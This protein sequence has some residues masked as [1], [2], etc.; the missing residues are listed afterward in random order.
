MKFFTKLSA[1]TLMVFLFVIAPMLAF[2]QPVND[3]CADAT[4]VTCGTTLSGTNVAATGTGQ[5]TTSCTTTPGNFGV[6]YKYVGTGD[7]VTAATCLTAS[8]DSKINVYSGSCGALV[9]IGGNDDGCGARSTVTFTTLVGTDYYI[10]VTGFGSATS[11]FT[12]NIT[13]TAPLANDLCSTATVVSCGDSLAASN[14]SAT[15]TDQ[16]TA[17]CGTAPGGPGV[18]FHFVGNGDVVTAATCA[19]ASY[20]SKLN[21]YSG[22]CGAATLVCVGGN[23]D[24]CGTRS[25]FTFPSTVGVDYYILVTGFSGATSNFILTINCVTPPPND[26]CATAIPITCASG[27]VYGTNSG[28]TNTGNPTTCGTAPGSA[29]V[30]YTFAGTGEFVTLSTCDSSDYNTKLN[31]YSGSCGTFA[32]VTGNDNNAACTGATTSSEVKFQSVAGVNYYVLV[33]GLG[34]ATGNFGLAISCAPS[35]ATNDSCINALAITCA[36][37]TV[38]GSNVV[39]TGN[40]DPTASCGSV[41]PGAYGVWYSFVGTGDGITLSTCAAGTN[42]DTKLNVYSGTC[43]S[44]VCVTGNDNNATCSTNANSSALSFNSTLGTQYYVLV[45]GN[46]A[47]NGNFDL[48]I[49]CTPPPANDSCVNAIALTCG[50]TVM[51]SNIGATNA[52]QPT[53]SCTT[54]P[55]SYG[56]WYTYTGTGEYVVLSTC[57]A[58][59]FDTKLNVYTGT[60]GAANLVCV[61]GNDNYTSAC[62]ANSSRL[63]FQSTLGTTYYVLVSGL[64]TATG[65]FSLTTTCFGAT[66]L[67]IDSCSGTYTSIANDTI[68]S[69]LAITRDTLNITTNPYDTISDLNVIVEATHS[70][71]GDLYVIL[72]HIP[73]GAVDTIVSRPGSLLSTTCSQNNINAKFDDLAL[74]PIICGPTT[75]TDS[76]ALARGPYQPFRPLSVFNGDKIGGLWEMKIVDASGGD[77]GKLISWCLD[78]TLRPY[79]CTNPVATFSDSCNPANSAFYVLVDVTDLGNAPSLDIT[80]SINGAVV[81]ASTAGHYVVGPFTPGASVDVTLTNSASGNCF[82]TEVGRSSSCVTQNPCV[83]PVATINAYC[84]PTDG[85]NFYVDVVV[86]DIGS[87]PALTISNTANGTTLAVT[88]AGTYTAGPF[89]NN[90][91][92]DVVLSNDTAAGC[93]VTALSLS[94]D[95]TP[96]CTTGVVAGNDTTICA[97]Q[98]VRLGAPAIS[99]TGT[100]QFEDFDACTLPLGWTISRTQ[101]TIDWSIG[102]PPSGN[103]SSFDGIN[104]TCLAYYDDDAAGNNNWNI[105]TLKSPPIDATTFITA[106]LNLDLFYNADE[107]SNVYPSNF[108]I[109]VWD[110]T[111]YQVLQTGNTS[112]GGGTWDQFLNSTYNLTPYLNAAMHIRFTYDDGDGW[113]YYVGFDNFAINASVPSSGIYTWTPATGLDDANSAVPLATPASTTTYVVNYVDGLCSYADTVTVT[114]NQLPLVAIAGA[115]ATYC[116]TESTPVQLFGLPAG[117]TFSG[118]GVVGST[119]VPSTAGAGTKIVTYTFTDGNG[120]A[121]SDSDTVL[122]NPQPIVTLSAVRPLYCIYDLPDTLFGSP[123]GGTYTGNGVTG[124]LFSPSAAGAGSHAITYV[125]QDPV[126]GCSDTASLTLSVVSVAVTF[127]SPGG[128]YCAEDTNRVALSVSPT[129]GTFVGPGVS[130]GQFQ[131]S[132]AGPGTHTLTYLIDSFIT[133]QLD[134]S[135]SFSP[136]TPVSPTTLTLGDDVLSAA[137]NLPFTF[138]FYGQNRTAIKISSNGWI[139]FNT[140]LTGSALGNTLLP[141]AGVPNDVIAG[142]WDDLFSPSVDYFTVG[143][144]PNRVFVVN[145]NTSYHFG[146]TASTVRFQIL[147]NEGSNIVQILCL[148]CNADASTPSATQGIENATGTSGITVPGRGDNGWSAFSDCT[149]FIPTSCTFSETQDVTVNPTPTASAGND[150][151]ICLGGTATLAATGGASY[152]WNNGLTTATITVSPTAT[153]PYS[154]RVTSAS[155]CVDLDT[156]VVTVLPTPIVALPDPTICQGSNTTLD[157]GNAGA[158]F[159]WSTTDTTQTINV[160]AAGDYA[161]TVTLASG[162]FATDTA[163]VGI[164]TSLTVNPGNPGICPGDTATLNAGNPGASYLWS[165]GALSQTIQ[166]SAPGIYTV[167]V[168]DANSCTGTGTSTVSINAVPVVSL[169]DPTI[170]VGSTT[171]LSAGNTGATFAWS[172]GDNTQSITVNNGGNYLVTVTNSFGCEDV[173]TATV[174]VGTGLVVTLPNLSICPGSTATLDAGYPGSNYLWNTGDTTQTITVTSNGGFVVTVTDNSG[175]SGVGGGSVSLRVPEAVNAGVD[176]GTCPGAN[177]VLTATGNV[178]SFL[179]TGGPGTASYT[180]SPTSTTTYTVTGTDANGCTSSDDVEV[181][182]YPTPAASAGAD[183]VSCAGAAV[184]LTA[185]GGV[186]YQWS[187][188]DNTATATVSPSGSITYTVTV[189]D[190]NGCTATDDVNVSVGSLPIVTLSGLDSLYCVSDP[191]VTLVGT[192]AGGTFS[193]VGVVGSTFN[194]GNGQ[195]GLN[196]ITYTYTDAN[197][198]TNSADVKFNVTYC[199][200]ID[201]PIFSESV[202]VYPNPFNN[203]V[204]VRFEAA[205]EY[206]ITVSMRDMLGQTVS[207]QQVQ[208]VAGA[209]EIRLDANENLAGGIYFVELQ[210]LKESRSFKLV[211]LR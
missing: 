172:T 97:G 74:S 75:G 128:P 147:L 47:A 56:V 63:G 166:V 45:S 109:A 43:A 89:V 189:T 84:N 107:F 202:T 165:T 91:L 115:G 4:L 148:D 174:T 191:L 19:T 69:A 136:I 62:S 122:V 207:Q 141:N 18:W 30:W 114:V 54:T 162:C 108:E 175:C 123:A 171:T 119:F 9:C 28:G 154:V 116:V 168:T 133:Y 34:A 60:C 200:G 12:F 209:N 11:A 152:L 92:V 143:T 134:T 52:N 111:A 156:V 42:F 110:G 198:C 41:T 127:N 16:P 73:T 36:T 58:A 131:P 181:A 112:I 39:A 55:G 170:C 121:N 6:W 78:P 124:N 126:T 93:N 204:F 38:S 125:Y 71:V 44:L 183:A 159:A 96:V 185:T 13:C 49:V 70:Y 155:G 76:S 177:V 37:G 197:G 161:V 142:M 180:V 164:S 102:I 167:S 199:T 205:Y 83:N 157:A 188:G 77:N 57:N 176:T 51:G 66:T 53:A 192:P 129:G 40:G 14:L 24:G 64:S 130:N 15:N 206:T 72:T 173:D 104:G 59:N 201:E 149:A 21:V 22:T 87:G 137:I 139:T 80:N 65:N 105:V 1:S 132:A 2:A 79:A 144:S 208:I 85:T 8:F 196:N 146:S 195:Y 151:S 117:G 31:V 32:C 61:T 163:T 20:D 169:P 153:T 33:S 194:P 120:C 46:S 35:Q 3:L 140:A 150:T 90:A 99:T 203:E 7:I 29:A 211:K 26:I 179:W 25:S 118:G 113:N 158:T 10:L 182:A 106:E 81:T 17:T 101:G 103:G 94:T 50:T 100:V 5:P 48:S 67:A 27:T 210:S 135:C 187:N 98:S 68:N 82:L 23:D 186:S 88:A 160:A 193:G 95:C 145:Y 190:G 178:N 184:S 138:K 86:T